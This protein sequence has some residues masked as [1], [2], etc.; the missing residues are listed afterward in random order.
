[1]AHKLV[2][3]GA[4][5]HTHLVLEDLPALPEVTFAACA[6]S[7]E[8]EDLS[9]YTR[10]LGASLRVYDDW[11][12][13]L[14]QEE[15]NLV[16][17][18]GRYDRNGPIAIEAARRGCHVFSEKPAAQDLET[19]DELRST[20]RKAGVQY[21]IMLPMRYRPAFYTAQRLVK[22]GT[23][24]EPYLITGQKS[25]RWGESRPEWYADPAKYGNSITWIGIHAFDLARW[26]AG[27]EFSEVWGYHA[28][29]VH[30]ERPGCQ[31]VS[32]VLTRLENGGSATFNLDY[33]RPAAAPT[34]GDDRLRVAGSQGVL[35]I[36]DE[37]TRLEVI[38]AEQAVSEWPLERV[39]RSIFRDF[40]AAAEGRGEMLISAEEAY[41]VTAFAIRAAAAA[42]SGRR[43]QL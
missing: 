39:E 22:Q 27:V 2:V 41:D 4:S 37:G 13:M 20:V 32:T 10:T 17:A 33:L 35:E 31:D 3:V 21:G 36:K 1:M 5:G 11:R 28:N 29:L 16:V 23:I 18:C 6:P 15:P 30:T 40:V 8:G 43:I 38:T 25:Y 42:D 7:Y 14:D 26:V 9:I 19:L 24:G 12:A 34:H